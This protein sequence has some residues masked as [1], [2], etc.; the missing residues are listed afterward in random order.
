MNGQTTQAPQFNYIEAEK[1]AQLAGQPPQNVQ[2]S[3]SCCTISS[4]SCFFDE[5]DVVSVDE[6]QS[7][8]CRGKKIC[9]RSYLSHN[10]NSYLCTCVHL[11]IHTLQVPAVPA[12]PAVPPKVQTT[13]A[14]Q[15]NY[16]ED[17]K[18]TQFA[19]QPPENVSVSISC[20]S[21]S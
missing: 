20:C 13:Q 10:M 5:F 9:I 16:V 2:V 3:V 11:H 21:I 1:K 15:F 17:E 7:S 12:V 18:K 8:T 4:L 19:G 14:P 6:F